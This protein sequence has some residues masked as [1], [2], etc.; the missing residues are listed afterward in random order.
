[1]N[2]DKQEIKTLFNELRT[3]ASKDENRQNITGFHSKVVKNG[4]GLIRSFACTDGHRLIEVK[5]KYKV[6]SITEYE[7][8][9]EIPKVTDLNRFIKDYSHFTS[10]DFQYC[11]EEEELRLNTERAYLPLQKI[12][13][14][15]FPNYS[16]LIPTKEP[17]TK[18][19]LDGPQAIKD[20][21]FLLKKIATTIK[22]RYNR[23]K[24]YIKESEITFSW[25]D[26]EYNFHINAGLPFNEDSMRLQSKVK[27]AMIDFNGLYLYDAFKNISAHTNQ[28]NIEIYSD[29]A[30]IKITHK[31]IYGSE[32]TKIIMPLKRS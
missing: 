9:N 7:T 32:I 4:K 21:T 3:F 16:P 14:C 24:V 15:S 13:G 5:N 18:I 22:D 1:M 31:D 30:P 6:G 19:F 20:I 12:D 8:I 17:S 28:I 27:R 10:F 29:V 26:K 2:Y 23:V 11:K 25:E